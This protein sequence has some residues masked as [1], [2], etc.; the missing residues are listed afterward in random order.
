MSLAADQKRAERLAR[1]A[2]L[3][4]E[5]AAQPVFAVGG[6]AGASPPVAASVEPPKPRAHAAET[7]GREADSRGDSFGDWLAGSALLS[8]N[9]VLS[10]QLQSFMGT[11]TAARRR[12]SLAP[13]GAAVDTSL[14]SL[15]RS[16][17]RASMGAGTTAALAAAEASAAA[18]AAEADAAKLAP[19]SATL[20]RHHAGCVPA[21]LA[22]ERIERVFSLVKL[23]PLDD[24]ELLRRRA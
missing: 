3:L 19:V 6:S 15:A 12:K 9:S 21:T 13:G 7:A 20:A 8:M 2:R 14:A 1:V 23:E 24:V 16:E 11:P 10:K 5:K 17:R 18:A 22:G 4:E